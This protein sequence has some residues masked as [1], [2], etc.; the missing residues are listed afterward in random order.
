MIHSAD[1]GGTAGSLGTVSIESHG[2]KLNQADSEALARRF[3]QAG[4]TLAGPSEPADIYVINTCT[5][6]QV[7]DGKARHALR[8]ARAKTPSSL[9]VAT[10][11]YA[12]RVPQEV[13]GVKGVDMV[14]GNSGKGDLVEMVLAARGD[15]VVPCAVGDDLPGF[16]GARAAIRTRAM[17]KIQEGC[18]QVCAYCIVPKVRGRE[19][20]I[21]TGV[22]LDEVRQ[23]VEEGYREVVL[24]GT[25]LGS[26]GF[27]LSDADLRGLLKLLLL[28]TKV[29][30]LRVSS[31]QPQEIN[32]ELLEL[33]RDPRLCPHFHMPLQSGNDSVL[34]RMRR[35]YTT[36]QYAGAVQR[37]RA[38][39]PGVSITAD[40]VVGFPGEGEGEFQE[41]LR[42]AR[43][44]E[45]ASM[46]VF[47]YSVRPGTSA[48]HMGPQVEHRT[49]RGRMEEMLALE[50]EQASAYRSR[51]IGTT[52]QVLWE[53]ADL[54]GQRPAYLGLTDNY[55]KVRTEQD[56]PLMNRITPARLVGEVG[57]TLLAHVL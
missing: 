43:E 41:S 32:R 20:S 16:P 24:T 34:K 18:N 1:N 47:P 3:I 31:L 40:V 7:A 28:E 23:R 54:R 57:E 50:R 36:A 17:V 8:A 12:E 26:Y 22:L 30:R 42:F 10:G 13:S 52:R 39:V 56:I 29:E 44:M 37:V 19:R 25:Q 14:V 55:M 15:Q 49:K 11:C 38:M 4:Y 33:W 51:A 21:P 9:V 45:F 2:C 27:D 53:R 48:A 35:R 6:T 5:V 46:H